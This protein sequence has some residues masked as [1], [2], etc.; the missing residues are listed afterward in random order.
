MSINAK[1]IEVLIV[2]DHGLFREGIRAMLE[3]YDDIKVV[4][5]ASDGIEAL[6]KIRQFAPD[7][8]LMD[9]SMPSMNGLEVCRRI[10]K[11][12]PN[13]KVIILT[14][15]NNKEYVTSA[16]KL[17]A[18]GFVP[19]KAA[20]SDL[21]SAIRVVHGGEY[22]LHPSAATILVSDYRGLTKL[23]KD[24][25]DALTNREREILQLVAEG[26]SSRQVA[27]LLH[28]SNKTAIGHRANIMN[29][30]NIHNRSDLIKYAIHK[31][32]I[33]VDKFIIDSD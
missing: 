12:S 19:K 20:A 11:I 13:T 32:L 1:I 29:K 27:D 26:L 28:I 5:E 30:L 4:G 14:Q 2:D 10:N 25:Y 23:N 21:L 22:F 3:S 33:N 6:D 9:I 24:E 31:G 17:G 16:V 18:S 7:V 8:V 15:H